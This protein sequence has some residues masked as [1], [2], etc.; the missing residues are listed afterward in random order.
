MRRRTFFIATA[1][2]LAGPSA[3]A[4]EQALVTVY[5]DPSC[6]CCGAWADHM[7][8]AG[9]T[10]KVVESSTLEKFKAEQGIPQALQSCH[11]AL[12]SG[13]VLEGHV[14]AKAVGKLLAER[15]AVKGLA[16]AG[17]PV[18]SPGMEMPGVEPEA[19]DV[20]TFGPDGTV[21]MRF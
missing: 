10:V 20:V 1:A 11:T 18:G 17:M 16:V 19:Y 6:G 9:F 3:F 12:V 8:K 2:L 5:K 21:F 14:P 15:P 13:Y 4:A 7:A